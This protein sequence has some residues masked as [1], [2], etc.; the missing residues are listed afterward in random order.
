MKQ[1]ALIAL[2]ICF[3][4]FSAAAEEPTNTELQANSPTPNTVAASPFQTRAKIGYVDIAKIASESAAGKAA[5]A[6]MKGRNEKYRTQI[7]SRQKSLEKLKSNIESQLPALSPLQRQAK[8][9]TLEKQVTEFQKYVQDAEKEMRKMEEEF[10]ESIFKSIQKAA[11]DYGKSNGFAA[12][13]PKRDLI[14][15]GDMV[16]VKDVTEDIIKDIR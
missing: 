12:I 5:T 3:F 9:K 14:Y 2:S 11:D 7:K 15:L 8:I 4:S 16:D 6:K 1:I 13:V 10:T